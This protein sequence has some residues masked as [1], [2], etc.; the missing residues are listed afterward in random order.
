MGAVLRD[1][2]LTVGSHVTP[3]GTSIRRRGRASVRTEP[4]LWA[5]R[6]T[7]GGQHQVGVEERALGCCPLQDRLLVGRNPYAL[8]TSQLC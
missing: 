2:A 6:L 8:V 5:V 7:P 4:S 1:S 3:G